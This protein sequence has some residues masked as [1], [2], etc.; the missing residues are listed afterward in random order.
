MGIKRVGGFLFVTYI[1]DHAPMY[2][3]VRIPG[4]R[5]L[6]RWD[7]Q[8]QKPLDRGLKVTNRLRKALAKAGYL[9]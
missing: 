7:I 2:V 8:D 9:R 1:G 3:H 4:G 5:E 6:G